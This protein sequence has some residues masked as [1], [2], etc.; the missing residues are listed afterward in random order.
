MA[1]WS[2]AAVLKTVEGHT[3]GG[4]NPSL[5]AGYWLNAYK[6]CAYKHF[7]LLCRTKVGHVSPD[8]KHNINRTHSLIL[9]KNVKKCALREEISHQGVKS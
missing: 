9:L 4:S 5:S 3:S 2:I 8:G 7:L 6:S 1:E